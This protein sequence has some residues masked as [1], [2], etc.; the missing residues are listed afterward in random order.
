MPGTSVYSVLFYAGML[1][2][3]VIAVNYLVGVWRNF[4]KGV[5]KASDDNTSV[6]TWVTPVVKTVLVVTALI[7]V[8]NVGWNIKQS[9]TTHSSKYV[10]PAETAEKKEVQE[11][12]PPSV[13]EMDAARAE[14]KRRS[15]MKPHKDALDSFDENMKQEAEKIRKR[16][17][18]E[19]TNNN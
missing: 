2:V 1:I 18:G 7:V 3:L 14:Q 15:E 16:S 8:F 12:Q 5:Q 6:P 10:N 13:Q 17:L 11:S 19:S 4:G 9:A